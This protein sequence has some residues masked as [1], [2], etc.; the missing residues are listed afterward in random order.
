MALFGR[1]IS[2]DDQAIARYH[3]MLKTAP[4]ETIEQAHAEAFAKLSPRSA[5]K[6]SKKWASASRPLSALRSKEAAR[7]QKPLHAP[8]HAQKCGS[9]EAW[10]E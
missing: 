2:A 6:C 4:P 8:P 10:A 3:Y 9:R 1:R 5:A 7:R